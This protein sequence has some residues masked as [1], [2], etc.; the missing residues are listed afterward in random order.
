MFAGRADTQVKIRGFR[1]EMGEI[2][3]VLGGF[4]GVREAVVIA[5][6]D[7]GRER[8]LAAYVVPEVPLLGAGL[9]ARAAK[10]LRTFLRERLP[11]HMVPAAFVLLDQMPLTPNRKIDRK[12]LPAPERHHAEDGYV[13]PRTPVEEVV[14]GVWTEVLGVARVGAHDNFFDLGGHSLLATQVISRLRNAFQVELPLQ[15]IFEEP[16]VAGLA[17]GIEAL[18]WIVEAKE[19]TDRAPEDVYEEGVL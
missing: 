13:A 18:R 2:E 14:A 6:Q 7:G 12:A 16:T 11:D 1:V 3:S 8:Y 19:T 4:P 5:R 10:T 17:K 15:R 9:A